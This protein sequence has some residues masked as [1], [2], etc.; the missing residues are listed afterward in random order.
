MHGAFTCAFRRSAFRAAFSSWAFFNAAASS[1]VFFTAHAK[2]K[3]EM[4][5]KGGRE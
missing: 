4:G 1:S 3:G 5:C 2:K